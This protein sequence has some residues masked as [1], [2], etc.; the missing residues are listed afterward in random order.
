MGLRVC[1]LRQSAALTAYRRQPCSGVVKF[2]EAITLIEPGGTISPI[3]GR[4]DRS[5]SFCYA[6]PYGSRAGAVSAALGRGRPIPVYGP[7]DEQGCDDLF[8]HP[9]CLIS[10][11]RW[12][13]L[14]CLIC[15]GSGHAPAAQPLKTD[16]RLSAGNAHSRVA[17]LSD[18]AGLPEKT[19]NFYAIISRR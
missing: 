10:A 18:T 8:K 2:N 17:W 9:A 19:L 14:W 3:A 12:N 11:T 1:G 16:L 15:R 4:P 5:S 7:P 13:R 6:L